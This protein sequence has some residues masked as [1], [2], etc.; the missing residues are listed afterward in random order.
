MMLLDVICA[1]LWCIMTVAMWAFYILSGILLVVSFIS[2]FVYTVD[3]ITA[4]LDE[5][6]ERLVKRTDIEVCPSNIP[7]TKN[8]VVPNDKQTWA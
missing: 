4:D 8:C 1:I 2:V 6:N 7:M 3:Q 5:F